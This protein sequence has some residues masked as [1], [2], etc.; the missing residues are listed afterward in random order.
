MLSSLLL[1]AALAALA[2]T[3][4][5]PVVERN[6]DLAGEIAALNAA[7]TANERYKILGPDGLVFDFLG[8]FFKLEGCILRGLAL[9]TFFTTDAPSFGGG[10]KD[11]GVV[12][13]DNTVFPGVI[14]QGQA[15][16]M[17]FLGVSPPFSAESEVHTQVLP[18]FVPRRLRN[19]PSPTCVLVWAMII[20]VCV[21]FDLSSSHAVKSCPTSTRGPPSTS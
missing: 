20:L 16:L 11:G 3:S 7:N 5:A 8:A 19:P 18:F 1:P 4:A 21:L 6:N 14:G 9:M 12:L 13:A 10:G 15:M 17:G 2:F